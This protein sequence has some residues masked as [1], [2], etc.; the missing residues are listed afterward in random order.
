MVKRLEGC[1]GTNDLTEWEES[2]VRS[3]LEKTR[4]GDDTRPLTERQVTCLEK[5]F[6][7]HFAD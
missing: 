5:I 3:I 2:F 1:L 7:K 6:K 4:H